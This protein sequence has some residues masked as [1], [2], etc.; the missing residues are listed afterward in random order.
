MAAYRNADTDEC[1][2]PMLETENFVSSFA[3]EIQS[4]KA[5]SSKRVSAVD[6]TGKR[7]VARRRRDTFRSKEEQRIC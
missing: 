7:Y 1:L 4:S 5:P 6:P 2:K 3:L